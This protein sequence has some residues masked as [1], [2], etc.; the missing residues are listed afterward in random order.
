M[1][2]DMISMPASNGNDES[3][4]LNTTTH[5]LLSSLLPLTGLEVKSLW[6]CYFGRCC[7]DVAKKTMERRETFT[8]CYRDDPTLLCRCD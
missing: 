3:P 4:T 8:R 6:G 5:T 2:C 7:K 1:D